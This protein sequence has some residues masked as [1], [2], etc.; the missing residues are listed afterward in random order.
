MTAAH[1][2]TSSIP[3][4]SLQQNSQGYL[5]S[6]DARGHRSN[7]S[8]VSTLDTVRK[9]SWDERCQG[10]HTG[11]FIYALYRGSIF[12]R[13]HTQWTAL[14]FWTTVIFLFL[15]LLMQKMGNLPIDYDNFL[16]ESSIV[17]CSNKIRILQNSLTRD[18]CVWPS[19][20]LA[21]QISKITC[22]STQEITF[23]SRY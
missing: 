8:A 21:G 12:K 23:L 4:G 17:Y 1:G 10:C 13:Q 3:S 19:K 5:V 2:N 9:Q 18:K 7:I 14:P 15:T 22:V 11:L 16:A 6:G 20:D